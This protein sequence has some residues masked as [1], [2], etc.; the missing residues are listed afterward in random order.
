[1]IEYPADQV[2]A[3]PIGYWSGA[4]YRA[5]VGRIRAELAFGQLTQPHWWTLNH[6]A[7]APG[8]W[9]RPDLADKLQPYDDL[10]IEMEDVFDELVERGWLEESAGTLTLT[11]E[12]EQGLARARERNSQAHA[13][14]LGGIS[15][16]DYVTTI[17]T[18]R[19]MIAN[20]GGDSDLP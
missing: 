9:T 6:V 7:G 12:G 14:T 5:V 16:E 8:T 11:A 10:G 1:M 2:A 3:Q 17:N 4:A 19:R 13:E 20:L 15:T 18:L